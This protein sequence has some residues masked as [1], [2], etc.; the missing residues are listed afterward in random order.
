MLGEQHLRPDG[1]GQ[2]AGATAGR[3]HPGDSR[4]ADLEARRGARLEVLVTAQGAFDVAAQP[5]QGDQIGGPD[6][7]GA[8]VGTRV[9]LPHAGDLAGEALRIGDRAEQV[10][11]AVRRDRAG[12]HQ[13]LHQNEA[14]R[15]GI[16]QEA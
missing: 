16:E 9:R 14:R 13:V 11:D 7:P 15:C 3:L 10:A 5:A 6:P 2:P 8:A 12:V 4:A 1:S